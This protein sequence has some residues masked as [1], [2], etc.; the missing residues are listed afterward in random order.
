[1]LQA[2]TD[3][4]P[5]LLQ[6]PRMAEMAQRFQSGDVP[7]MNEIM[8]DPELRNVAENFGR[9]F[10]GSGANNSSGASEDP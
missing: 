10:G 2:E 9:N 3:C 1:M 8:G 6:N 7:S 5:G 4:I